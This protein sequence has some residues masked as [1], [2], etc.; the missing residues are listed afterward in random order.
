MVATF[1]WPDPPPTTVESTTVNSIS[2]NQHP[3]S[4]HSR[5]LTTY[6]IPFL[7]IAAAFSVLKHVQSLLH[8]PNAPD[9]QSSSKPSAAATMLWLCLQVCL[10]RSVS[11]FTTCF[12]NDV[13]S[14]TTAADLQCRCGKKR[15]FRPCDKRG[16]RL[17]SRREARDLGDRY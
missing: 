17:E 1:F 3:H 6:P 13:F 7:A 12:H 9:Y 16:D 10:Y 8:S 4:S 2:P 14:P 5:G 11:S 15:V